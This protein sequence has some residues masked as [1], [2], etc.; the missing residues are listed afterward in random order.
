[1]SRL[2]MWWH[3]ACIGESATQRY[4]RQQSATM[5]GSNLMSD[6][7]LQ[8]S[9]MSDGCARISLIATGFLVNFVW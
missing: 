4:V 1:M 5:S 6:S 7:N 2:M 9:V 3:A 8:R